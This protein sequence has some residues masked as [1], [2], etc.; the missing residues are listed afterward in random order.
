MNYGPASRYYDLFAS[1]NEVKFYKELALENGKKKRNED[2]LPAAFQ[3]LLEPGIGLDDLG[4]DLVLLELRL[5]VEFLDRLLF[6]Q[7]VLH[8]PP[9]DLG[10]IEVILLAKGEELGGRLGETLGNGYVYLV[11]CLVLL[12]FVIIFR[13]S[14]R[15]RHPTTLLA[16]ICPAEPS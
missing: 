16:P 9:D 15:S 5:L 11:S 12:W 7:P 2:C 8:A 10:G 6:P 1:V 4:N 13:V 3:C 14:L